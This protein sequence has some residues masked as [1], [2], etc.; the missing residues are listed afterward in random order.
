MQRIQTAHV[1]RCA[2]HIVCWDD[3]LLMDLVDFSADNRFVR[4]CITAPPRHTRPFWPSFKITTRPQ[5]WISAHLVTGRI[6]AAAP[7]NKASA[8]HPGEE[9]Y[10]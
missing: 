3:R 10:V 9:Q 8:R 5:K 7:A 6:Q 2:E 4:D 1:P